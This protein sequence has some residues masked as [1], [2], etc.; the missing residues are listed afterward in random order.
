MLLVAVE[1]LHR[2]GQHQ[3]MCQHLPMLMMMMMMT[4]HTIM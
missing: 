1:E 4:M 2:H 3:N